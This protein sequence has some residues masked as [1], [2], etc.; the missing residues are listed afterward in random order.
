[1]VKIRLKRIGQRNRPSYRIVVTESQRSRDGK[2]IEALGHYNPRDKALVVNKERADYWLSKGAQ[3]SDTAGRLLRRYAKLSNPPPT[4][5]VETT[6]PTESGP[7][8]TLPFVQGDESE[9]A[10]TTSAA[11]EGG[12]DETTG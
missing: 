3:P 2:Y 11:S 9:D 8:E 1:M 4:A 12:N 7:V 6:P 5:P 10:G